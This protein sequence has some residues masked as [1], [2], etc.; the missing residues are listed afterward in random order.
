MPA[1][2]PSAGVPASA[3][4]LLVP[5]CC[6]GRSPGAGPRQ[7]RPGTSPPRR[8]ALRRPVSC[9][10]RLVANLMS[11]GSHRGPIQ[12]TSGR[13]ATHES[14]EP[15]ALGALPAAEGGRGS[16]IRF[17]TDKSCRK[18]GCGSAAGVRP[19]PAMCPCRWAGGPAL[20]RPAPAASV[21]S[22]G[23]ERLVAGRYALMAETMIS[24]RR[25]RASPCTT[26][27]ASRAASASSR[28][29]RASRRV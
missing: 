12:G 15:R 5:A 3:G 13:C 14:C 27:V 22:P 16:D 23:R 2:P 21:A 1:L 4:V 8:A 29:R 11:S 19:A 7:I 9:R 17:R 18:G 24:R 25:S 28:N 26:P 20:P 6:S 10:N